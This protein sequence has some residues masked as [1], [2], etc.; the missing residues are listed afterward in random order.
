[1]LAVS[2]ALTVQALLFGDGGITTLGANCFNMAIAGSLAA[3]LVL[4]M[5]GRRNWISC[6]LAGYAAVNVSAL[7][8]AI[9]FGVQPLWFHDSGGTPLYAPYPLA[10]A[11]PAMM[12][13]HLTIAGLA[14]AAV[15][16]GIF[17]YLQKTNPGLVRSG[18]DEPHARRFPW[19]ALGALVVLTPLGLLA[20]TSAWGEWSPKELAARSHAGIPT[21]LQHLFSVWQAPFANYAPSFLHNQALAYILSAA[22]GGVAIVLV[23]QTLRWAGPRRAN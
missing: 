9:E 13:G 21:G 4:R 17:A 10:I 20:A 19:A 7:L 23:V 8:A 14:E 11:I 2:I 3:G 22:L 5:A 15:S 6:A 1:M 18:P 16:G 12:V